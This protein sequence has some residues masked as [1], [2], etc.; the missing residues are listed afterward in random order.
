MS[1][2]VT[3]A[4]GFLGS[5][6]VHGLL[7]RGERVQALVRAKDDAEARGRLWTALEL[8]LA[9]EDGRRS[10]SSASDGGA[11]WLAERLRDGRLVPVRGDIRAP[12]LG[13]STTDAARVD[14]E[15]ERV[16]HTAAS[17]NRRSE[18]VCLDVN[19]RGGLE[20]V[21]LARR[22]ADRGRLRR[23]VHTSTVAVAGK[24]ER[25]VVR[26]DEAIDWERGDFDPYART[27]KM[28][29]QLVRRLLEGA[30][31]IVVRPSIVMGDSRFPETTQFDM[32]R[33][34]VRLAQMPVLPLDPDARLD[35]I[36]ADVVGAAVVELALAEAPKYSTYHLSAGAASP[37]VRDVTEALSRAR[38]GRGPVFAK[39]LAGPVGSLMRT[40]ANAGKSPVQRIAALMEVF[41]PYLGWDVVFDN[42]RMIE[43]LG[44]SPAPFTTYC[45]GLYDFATRGDFSYPHRPVP[46]SVRSAGAR[47][48][49][50]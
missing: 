44:R 42:S 17:L 21:L 24:R 18:R 9:R 23:Y 22:L 3:G 13:L 40:L 15:A 27:K 29:E 10:A 33:A 48:A 38:G 31:A 30:S 6:V 16:V 45:A 12:G 20:V 4:T 37:T 19:L 14:G 5:Y 39:P 41:W 36:P 50:V 35:I 34:F 11:S 7:S 8:H 32:V 2:L 46:E 28:G 43:G 25:E 47:P 1:T 26:E 49:A